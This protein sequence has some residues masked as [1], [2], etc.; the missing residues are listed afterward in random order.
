MFDLFQIINWREP[1]WLLVV[2]QP[3]LLWLVLRWYQNRQQQKFADAHLLPYLQVHEDKTVWQGFVSSIVS[4]NAAY[5]LAWFLFSLSLAGPR[6]PDKPLNNQND[7]ILDVMM[8]VDLSRSMLVTDIK[9]SR[10]RRATLE[11]YDFLSLA[12][13]TRVGITVYAARP[14]LFVPLTSDFKALRFYLK[15]LDTLQLPTLGSD[16][17]TALA[18]ANKEL[19][20]TKGVHKQILLWLTDG[21]IESTQIKTIEKALHKSNQS[22]IDTYILGLGTSEGGSIP[23][24]D[25][26]WLES[27]GLAVISKANSQLLQQFSS[28]GKGLYATVSDDNA[29]WQT[30]YQQGML[31]SLSYPEQSGTQ[32]WKE[33]FAWV[34]FPAILLLIIALFPFRLFNKK[35]AGFLPPLLMVILVTVLFPTPSHAEKLKEKEYLSTVLIGIDAYKNSE[36]A[37]SKNQF[38]QSVLKAETDK[39]RGVALHNLGNALFQTGDY[40]SAAEVFTDALRYAPNQRESIENQK[41]AIEIY[42][43]IE[44]RKN[45]LMNRGNFA[46]PEDNAPLFDLPEQIPFILSSKAVML[47][48]ASLPDLPEENLDHLISEEML[49]FQLKQGDTTQSLEEQK[50]LQKREQEIEQARIHFMG[51]EETNTNSLWKRLFEIEEGFPAKLKKPKPIPGLRPW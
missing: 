36:Y 7:I 5:A 6:L 40:S 51:L 45:R 41:L 25:G 46:A 44:K 12:K 10:L 43:L 16:A 32:Q 15:N 8:V 27:D 14:H 38:V 42:T 1:L 13:N 31:Q 34:L 26:N 48:K 17:S 23:L 11:A 21:D 18:F 30:L 35:N 22:N 33:L 39:E 37:K 9:P 3:L 28:L 47:L 19:Q 50:Q 20:D 24:G 49:Q 29:D 2:L 4:R